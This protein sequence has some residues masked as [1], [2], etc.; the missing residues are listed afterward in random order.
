MSK[1]EETVREIRERHEFVQ[2]CIDRG[3]VCPNEQMHQDRGVLLDRV[4]KLEQQL[5]DV[6]YCADCFRP[7]DACK[8]DHNI[9]YSDRSMYR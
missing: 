6:G 8:C 4:A 5:E 1:A 3:Q 2:K 9:W 7:V